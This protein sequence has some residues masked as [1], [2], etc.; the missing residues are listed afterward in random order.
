M[1]IEPY[2][3]T[4]QIVEVMHRAFERYKTDPIPSSA[5]YETVDTVQQELDAGLRIF[6]GL[7]DGEPVAIVKVTE[8]EDALYFSRLSVL[9][10]MQSKGYAKK[11][12]HFIEQQARLQGKCSVTCRVRKTEVGNIALYSKLGY[13]VI[14]EE[15]TANQQEQGMVV[16]T[17]C[18]Q[19]M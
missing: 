6:G 7:V 2:Q 14:V 11:L 3:N 8:H 16:M 15:L 5:L 13:V 1:M 10:T 18:K 19:L 12:V 9:P 17:M 4:N